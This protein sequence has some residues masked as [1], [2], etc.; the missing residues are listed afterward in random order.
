MKLEKY[1]IR[2]QKHKYRN[3]YDKYNLNILIRG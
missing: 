2:E 1:Y 3:T